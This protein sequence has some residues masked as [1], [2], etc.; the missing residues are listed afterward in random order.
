MALT[1]FNRLAF[2]LSLSIVLAGCGTPSG[3]APVGT[4]GNGAVQATRGQ[5]SGSKAIQ[6]VVIIVQDSR[7][8][9]NLFCSYSGADAARCS[10]KAQAIPLEAKCVISDTFEDFQ[11]DRKTGS[12]SG[13]K[14]KCPGY[15]R[16][17]YGTVPP[18]E[19]K[20]YRAIA[21]SYVLADEM[22]SST[23][24]PTFESHQYHIAAQAD[25]DVDQ[26]FGH[27]GPDGCVYL[28][29]VRQFSGPPQP[30]CGT[31]KTIADELSAANLTWAYYAAGASEPTWDAFGWVKGYSAG[32]APPTQFLTDVANGKLATVTWVTPERSDSDLS[33]SR[34]ATGPAWVA[35]VVNAVGESKFWDSTAIFVTWSGFGGW[36]DH[37]PPPLLDREGL[38]FRVPFLVVSPYAK[39]GHVSHVQYETTSIL[40]FV[41][42]GFGLGQLSASDSRAKSPATDC[43]DFAQKPRSFSPI[44]SGSLR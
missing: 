26:P 13:E 9:D 2:G 37:V 4:V 30:A 33:G 35:S 21:A 15:A 38:G 42:D 41:E 19:T 3:L 36:A 14:A 27:T 25:N 29:K 39:Q 5:A 1:R 12:F 40:R 11:R 43:F 24:N 20:A 44:P 31:Y 32:I 22:F 34:S 23:G 16:P 18:T 17:E 6:H 8:F 10:S 7:S 28:A